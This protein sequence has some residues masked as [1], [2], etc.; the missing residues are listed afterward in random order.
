[1]GIGINGHLNPCLTQVNSS[2]KNKTF[3]FIFFHKLIPI[4]LTLEDLFLEP[5][6]LI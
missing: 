5:Q 4:L 6:G 3:K 1:M 2:G